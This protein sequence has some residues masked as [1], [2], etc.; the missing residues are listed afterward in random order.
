MW[1]VPGVCW[2]EWCDGFTDYLSA[3]VIF[4][5]TYWWLLHNL[6]MW[7]ENAA[8]TT[9]QCDWL[10]WSAVSQYLLHVDRYKMTEKYSTNGFR[11]GL[12]DQSL[13]RRTYNCIGLRLKQKRCVQ[14]DMGPKEFIP[15]LHHEKT[16]NLCGPVSTSQLPFSPC[17]SCGIPVDGVKS[18]TYRFL[19][20]SRSM[21][22]SLGNWWKCKKKAQC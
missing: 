1:H 10:Q 4:R 14:C 17:Q 6:I 21:N 9:V 12:V 13:D 16:C 2:N 15:V 8:S 11:P 20:S 22:Y 5:A 19:F 7:S 3:L 18:A